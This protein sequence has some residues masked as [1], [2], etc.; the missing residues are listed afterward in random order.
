MKKKLFILLFTAITVPGILNCAITEKEGK[1]VR[2]KEG[3]AIMPFGAFEEGQYQ[4]KVLS[5]EAWAQIY[6][7]KLSSDQ[8]ALLKEY[9]Q[10]KQEGW[11]IRLKNFSSIDNELDA[12]RKELSLARFKTAFEKVYEIASKVWDYTFYQNKAYY[13]DLI[14]AAEAWIDSFKLLLGK[15]GYLEATEKKEVKEITQ[16]SDL[17]RRWIEYFE[18]IKE[19]V[20]SWAVILVSQLSASQKDLLNKIMNAELD[21]GY[22]LWKIYMKNERFV[23]NLRKELNSSKLFFDT[24]EQLEAIIDNTSYQLFKKL[25]YIA[26]IRA[27]QNE[28][29]ALIKAIE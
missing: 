14:Y 16:K 22:D 11:K 4:Q 5:P 29:N 18:K 23:N 20:T 27:V 25:Y 7:S 10:I 24:I 13:H 21:T 19:E 17:D 28:L 6:V 26:E 1:E 12:A 15:T 9:L 3:K 8:K 2:A